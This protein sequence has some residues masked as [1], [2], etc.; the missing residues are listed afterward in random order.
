MYCNYNN[1]IVTTS[2]TMVATSRTT[3]FRQESRVGTVTGT[4]HMGAI[5]DNFGVIF[6]INYFQLLPGSQK[7][8]KSNFPEKKINLCIFFRKGRCSLVRNENSLLLSFSYQFMT[9]DSGKLFD[10]VQIHV[11]RLKFG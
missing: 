9:I 10:F 2:T 4:I 1:V 5:V 6:V 8:Q 7:G 3:Q 11:I